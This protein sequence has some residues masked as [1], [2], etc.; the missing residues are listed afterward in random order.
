MVLGFS[1]V[2]YGNFKDRTDEW[3]SAVKTSLEYQ[4]EEKGEE[5]DDGNGFSGKEH[6]DRKGEM[7]LEHLSIGDIALTADCGIIG[8]GLAVWYWLLCMIW[9]D[10]RFKGR[11][12]W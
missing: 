4:D 5:Q 3:E 6:S 7:E 10:R 9:A 2:L 11:L 1:A 8:A 12:L